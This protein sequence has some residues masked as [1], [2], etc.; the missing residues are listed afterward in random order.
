MVLH[1]ALEQEG[2][3]FETAMR[4]RIEP[5]FVSG[6]N[7][8]G[9]KVVQHQERAG[10]VELRA[11]KGTQHV[12]PRGRLRG[13]AL[14]HAQCGPGL[15][16]CIGCNNS[17]HGLFLSLQF[18]SNNSTSAWSPLSMTTSDSPSILSASPEPSGWPLT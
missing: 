15:D 17:V 2:H 4:M 18:R 9:S 1:R 3:G 16:L 7:A 10:V 11:R 8:V 6:P 13:K 14:H 12:Q 5:A